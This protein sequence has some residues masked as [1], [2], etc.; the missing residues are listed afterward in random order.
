MEAKETARQLINDQN[1]PGGQVG[2]G[3]NL[4]VAAN[5][6]EEEVLVYEPVGSQEG[7]ITDHRTMPFTFWI[8]KVA[9]VCGI[10]TTEHE[11]SQ[12][13]AAL[14]EE[15]RAEEPTNG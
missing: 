6:Q 4:I 8:D 15:L 9:Q 5:A 10:T 2:I 11:R 13:K 14:L 3:F 7:L 1:M 12:L